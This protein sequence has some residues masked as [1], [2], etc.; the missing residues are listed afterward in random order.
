MAQPDS[1]DVYVNALLT[2]LSIGYSNREYVADRV[3]P[4][5]P[6]EQQSGI[7]PSYNRGDWLRSQ[8]IE[9]APGT[10]AHRSGWRTDLTDTYFARNYA[11]GK[12]IPREVAMNARAPFDM[13]RD[14]TRF[15]TEQLMLRR[16]KIFAAAAMATGVWGTDKTGTTDF[17]K[18]SDY[19]G[20]DPIGDIRDGRRTVRQATGRAANVACC[21]E[22]VFDALQ[23][24]PDIL[25]RIKGA[26]SPGNPAIV[27]EGL[28]A[29]L[30]R[31]EDFVVASAIEVTSKEGQSTIT[32]AD[33]IDDDMLL[34]YRTRAPSLFEPSAGY[35]I[36]W[37]PATGGGMQFIRQ[38]AE[39][40]QM[41]TVVEGHAYTQTKVTSSISG[42]FF[43]DA[44]D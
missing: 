22:I 37:R 2:N 4:P 10:V 23:D 12:G 8:A 20:S 17:V 18:W 33:V 44:V 34:V 41:Q 1:N 29:A 38:Y 27:T 16:E 15:V 3:L 6:V 7:I 43:A 14:A 35:Q 30:F 9:R 39:G 28:L 11:L 36:Y 32:T 26:A 5:L 13:D 40:P 31:L 19:A 42:Y 21:G 24:H 25:D